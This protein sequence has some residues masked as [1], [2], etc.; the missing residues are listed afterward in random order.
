MAGIVRTRSRYLRLGEDN[1]VEISFLFLLLSVL[2]RLVLGL[3]V[4]GL[5]AIGMHILLFFLSAVPRRA[6]ARALREKGT[7]LFYRADLPG[8][9]KAGG[10]VSHV[11]GMVN[12]FL[13]SGFR[14]VYVADAN[15]DSV[16]PEVVQHVVAPMSLLDF[17]DEFQLLAYNYQLLMDAGRLIRTYRPSL[18]YQRHGIL[19]IAGGLI[20]KRAGVPLVLEAN[21]SEVW[22]KE[23]WSRLV[24]RG[25]AE[26]CE[27]VA[28]GLADR[29][30]VISEGVREQLRPYHV[31]AEKVILN[32]N[33][34]DPKEFRPVIDG[35]SVRNTYGLKNRIVVG[36]IGTFT[37]WHGVE[38]LVEAALEV[39]RKNSH[40]AFLL[41]GDG[42]L[43][44]ALENRVKSEGMEH[45]IIFTGIVP[46]TDAPMF[47]A[48]CDI[49]VSPHLGFDNN[50]KFFGSPTKL[51]EYMA[52]GK[53]IIASNLEQIGEVIENNKTGLH[54]QPGD[55]AG[56]AEKILLL[57]GD[58]RLR[59]ELGSNAHSLVEKN[60]TWR[61]NVERILLSLSTMNG[62]TS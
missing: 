35:L 12:A 38:I 55:A 14:V 1:F 25:L 11:K 4:G 61:K 2:P 28:L 36:F 8:T 22:V 39:V 34:V 10:S 27:S 9:L 26:K 20:A 17:F 48:A 46:H 33:G 32:P 7:V 31:P 15:I 40:V 57:A 44:S 13:A 53:A 54:C 23:H 16:P 30:A 43:R 19:N 62:P 18:I 29:V 51:F 59:R 56:L 52:M 37:K 3:I 50:E 6:E 21:A 49:L 58:E 42:D 60:Y 41:I 24:F 47:L 5:A 45:R